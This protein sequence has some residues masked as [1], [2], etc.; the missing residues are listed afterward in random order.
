MEHMR[1]YLQH[2]GAYW[3]GPWHV[4]LSIMLLSSTVVLFCNFD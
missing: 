2:A 4:E 1:Q 3:Q